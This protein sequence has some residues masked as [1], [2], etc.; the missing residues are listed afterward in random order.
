[1]FDSRQEN[2]RF[3]YL[4]HSVQTGSGAHTAP[5]PLYTVFSE[6]NWPEHE[7]NHSPPSN[8]DVKYAEII[9]QLTYTPL[10]SSREN[11]TF[12]LTSIYTVRFF[13]SAHFC[14]GI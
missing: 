3:F 9:P 14:A 2:K 5:Y 13:E 4:L 8:V 7:T 12:V 6:V 10:I 1:V 11:F